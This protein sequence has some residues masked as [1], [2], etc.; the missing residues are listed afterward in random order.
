MKTFILN[1]KEIKMV[2]SW[3]DLSLKQWIEFYKLNEKKDKE[4]MVQDFYLLK[5][6]EILCD[7]EPDGLDDMTLSMYQENLEEMKFMLEVPVSRQEQTLII[8]NVRYGFPQNYDMNSLTAGEYISIQTLR[9]RYENH[10]DSIPWLLAV[11]LRPVT[12]YKNEETGEVSW[13]QE[14]FSTENLGFR[15]ELFLNSLKALDVM[16]VIT[17][18][19]AGNKE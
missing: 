2:N 4:G 13:K 9:Q 1:E 6:M 11:I 7:A 14:K 8:N 5:L 19:F 17:F 15:A 16:S 12:E 10:L 18:F 3:E